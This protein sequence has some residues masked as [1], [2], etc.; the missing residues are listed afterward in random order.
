MFRDHSDGTMDI[1]LALHLA[2]LDLIPATAMFV[3][4]PDKNNDKNTNS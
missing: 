1:A 4:K 3:P 2:N